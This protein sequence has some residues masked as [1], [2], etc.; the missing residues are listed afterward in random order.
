MLMDMLAGF[1]LLRQSIKPLSEC[2]EKSK[3]C[4]HN[5]W[6]MKKKCHKEGS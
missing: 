4:T 3:P 5:F 6:N 1:Q 2:F